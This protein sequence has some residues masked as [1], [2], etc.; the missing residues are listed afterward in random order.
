ML[1]K[2]KTL[3]A[4]SI[5]PQFL[6]VIL[7]SNY[8]SF[9][10]NFYSNGLYQITSKAL[11][12]TIGWLPFSFGD[13]FYTFAGIYI[14]RWLFINRKRIIKDTK[15]WFIDVFVAVSLVYWV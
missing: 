15:S 5:F 6:I 10:E 2:K 11:R 4:L 3:I 1:N 14:L 13:L 8:P 7:L 12:F 9:V